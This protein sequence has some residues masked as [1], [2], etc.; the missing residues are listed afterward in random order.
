MI[1]TAKKNTWADIFQWVKDRSLKEDKRGQYSSPKKYRVNNAIT[2]ISIQWLF[3]KKINKGH[4]V[5][6]WHLDQLMT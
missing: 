3:S 6:R 1:A 2:I 4:K 5:G